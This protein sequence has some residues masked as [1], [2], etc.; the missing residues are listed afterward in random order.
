MVISSTD[1]LFFNQIAGKKINAN[2]LDGSVKKM[3]VNG[4]AKSIYYM[5]DD[6]DAYIGVNETE[7]SFM[8]FEFEKNKIEHV[9]SY[10]EPKSIIKPMMNTDHE[11][12]KL[13]GFKWEID[14]R[15][16]NVESL[17]Y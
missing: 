14:L 4:N 1:L 15:P 13:K 11:L 2:F 12:L 8:I 9:R 16:L 10:T 6:V 3:H 7:A 17:K 5:L